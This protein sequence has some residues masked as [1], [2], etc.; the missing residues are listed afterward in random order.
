MDIAI[1]EATERDYEA[2]CAIIEQVDSIHQDALP[3]RFKDSNGPP[4][5]REYILNAI[6]SPDVDIFVAETE[7][8]L[9]GFVHVM[10]RNVPDIPIL[11]PRRHAVVENLAVREEHRRIGIGLALMERAEDWARAKGAT[12]IELNVYAFND[13]AQRFY[14]KLGY[15]TLSCRMTKPL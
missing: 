3:K 15:E 12:S 2:L 13:V 6:R 4:R 14:R 1:R 5:E 7:S 10:I 9:V 11:V 8:G